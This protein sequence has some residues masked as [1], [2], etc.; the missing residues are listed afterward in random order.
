M[1]K[2]VFKLGVEARS[3]LFK[4]AEVLAVGVRSTLGPFGGYFALDKGNEITTDGVTVAREIAAG[5]IHDEIQAKGARMLLEA[6]T[7]TEERG[8]DGTTTAT[9]LT[10][11]I[12]KEAITRL[13]ELG[14]HVKNSKKKKPSEIK[15]QLE[16]ECSHVIKMLDGMAEKIKDEKSLIK[17]AFISAGNQDIAD[18]IGKT[19]WELGPQGYILVEETAE[20]ISSVERIPGIRTDNGIVSSLAINNL[21][22]QALEIKDVHIILTDYIIKDLRPAFRNINQQTGIGTGLIDY[23]EERGI[24]R[25]ILFGRHFEELAIRQCMENMKHGM[26]I[27]PINA[28]Y[29][30]QKEVMKDLMAVTGGRFISTDSSTL[31]AITPNDVGYLANFIATR[32][33]SIMTGRDDKRMKERITTRIEELKTQY[34][35][36]LSDFEKKLIDQRIAQLSNGFG[37]LKIGSITELDRKGLKRKADDA[38]GA[39]R[40]AFQEGVIPGAGLALKEISESLPEDSILKRPLLSIN[41]QIMDSAPAGFKVE[42]WVKDPVKVIRIALEHACSIASVFATVGGVV[43]E[44]QAKPIDELFKS[45]GN[46]A[47]V[48]E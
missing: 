48:S 43:C 8:V 18:L 11:E 9:I 10:Y 44:E 46:V 24:K 28:P 29:V 40:A 17:S 6:A 42:K 7:K 35:G 3:E 33:N 39:V 45:K 47:T 20:Q 1:K 32:T 30:D 14:S 31:E 34:K 15:L 13:P 2:R 4:G 19:Q 38:V 26:E 16:E 25:V 41:K 12:T 5:A 22:K 21:E 36:S 27:Y 23:L 37:L